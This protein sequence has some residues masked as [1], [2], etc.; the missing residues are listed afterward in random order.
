MY[1]SDNYLCCSAYAAIY[2]NMTPKWS[3]TKGRQRDNSVDILKLR[4]IY[5]NINENLSDILDYIDST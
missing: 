5:D 3:E 1:H 2:S 4:K